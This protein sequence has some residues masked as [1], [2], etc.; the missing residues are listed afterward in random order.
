MTVWITRIDHLPVSWLVQYGQGQYPLVIIPTLDGKVMQSY[1]DGRVESVA[2]LTAYI[3]EL[4]S[5]GF[6][7]CG[8]QWGH[9][10]DPVGEADAALGAINAIPFDGWVMNGEKPYEGGFRSGAYTLRFRESRPNFPFGWTPEQR[11]DLDHGVLQQKGVFY[12]PQCYPLEA[13]GDLDYVLDWAENFGYKKE[14]TGPLVQAY[15]TNNIRPSAMNF[16]DTAIRRGI[17]QLTMYTGNQCL[18]AFEYWR[19]L[20]IP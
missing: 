20:V 14:N 13:G 8:S 17:G 6:K 4:H 19:N 11:L 3:N 5:H 12:M 18:D 9:G 10:Q 15:P 7:V 16:R 2:G 1:S